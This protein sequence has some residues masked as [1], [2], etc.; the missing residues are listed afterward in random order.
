MRKLSLSSKLAYGFGQLAEGIK[1]ASFSL[2]LLYYYTQILGLPGSLAGA[3]IFIALCFDAVT[4]PLTGFISDNFRSRWGRRHPFMYVSA[5]PFGICFYYV[6]SPPAGLGQAGLFLW[7]LT[8][9]VLA[10]TALTLYHVPHMALGAELTED[11]IDRTSIVA[12][13]SFFGFFGGVASV[14][15]TT[16]Y[17]FAATPEYPV[18]QNNPAA[19]PAF[20]HFFTVWIVF[21]IWLSAYGTHKEIPYIHKAPE[22]PVPF[23][24]MQIFRDIYQA[25]GNHTFRMLFFGSIALTVMGGLQTSLIMHFGT[26]FLEVDNIEI[27]YIFAGIGLGTAVGMPFT[28]YSNKWFDKKPTLLMAMIATPVILFIPIYL[29]VI[30]LFPP[31]DDPMM[32]VLYIPFVTVATFIGVQG[33]ITAGSLVADV[34]DEHEVT[35]GRRQEGIFFGA[36]SFLGKTVHGLGVSI[37][38]FGLDLINFP[39]QAEPGTV[40]PVIVDRLG[41]FYAITPLVTCLVAILFYARIRITRESHASTLDKLEA[42][43]GSENK[44]E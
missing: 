18:G 25:L 6:F 12:Y 43:R 15:F 2:A 8:F 10:R 20:A 44:E 21:S 41:L 17:F 11:Y 9:C 4:D 42:L 31:N 36:Q 40:D 13:R 35:T 34:V 28:K 22:K 26:F 27:M 29:M 32:L 5:L 19:Y 16:L 33:G 3:A 30:D 24:F 38:G 1:G 37:A 23:K 7:M 39:T 14:G